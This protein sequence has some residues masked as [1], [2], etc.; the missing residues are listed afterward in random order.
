MVKNKLYLFLIATMLAVFPGCTKQEKLGAVAPVFTDLTYSETFDG[1]A[2]YGPA[3]KGVDLSGMEFGSVYPG[4][5]GRD[6]VTPTTQEVDYYTS[7]GMNVFRI[8]FVWERAQPV[9]NG[10]LTASYVG[11][12]KNLVD[13]ASVNK[14]VTT[15]IEPHNFAKYR[16]KNIGSPEVPNAAF[17]DFWSKM[18][19][20][21]KDNPK[22]VF[23][24]VNEPNGLPTEQWVAGANAAIAAIRSAG[25]AH[26]IHVP[27]NAWTAAFHWNSN[28]YGTANSVAMLKIVDPGNNFLY[29]AHQY[30]DSDGSGGGKECVSATVGSQRLAVFVNWLRAN[31]KRGFIGE[32]GAPNTP[33]CQ[34]AMTDMIKYMDANADVIGGWIWWAGGPGWSQTYQLSLE[35]LTSGA[36]RAQMTW[37][38]PYLIGG[39]P[40]KITKFYPVTAKMS[41]ISNWTTGYCVSVY[42]SNANVGKDIV[43]S[44]IK[45]DLG[46]AGLR[47]VWGGTMSGKTGAV[48]FSPNQP[49]SKNLPVGSKTTNF[50]FCVNKGPKNLPLTVSDLK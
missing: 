11:K 21:Y 13:Y 15:I 44:S 8:G 33:L 29:E 49:W 28:W 45:V 6:W 17:A 38:L 26:M 27:G 37:L 43:W 25:C 12:L 41:V 36:D 50:G 2:P 47:D 19:L 22:V 9:L 20:Q 14:G 42:L 23:N 32:I 4:V 5:E 39:K 16:G 31:G 18:C 24:L 1:T 46:D 35:P 30:I 10:P 7:R 3:L 40:A 48:V 34:S